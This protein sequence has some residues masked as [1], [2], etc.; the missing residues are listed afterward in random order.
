MASMATAA[1]HAESMA[2]YQ[3]HMHLC[4]LKWSA[5]CIPLNPPLEREMKQKP[6]VNLLCAIRP[7]TADVHRAHMKTINALWAALY[8][9]DWHLHHLWQVHIDSLA[10]GALSAAEHMPLC[11]TPVLESNV[12]VF[13]DFGMLHR[14]QVGLAALSQKPHVE[15][16]LKIRY[17]GDDQVPWSLQQHAKYGPWLSKPKIGRSHFVGLLEVS[18][19]C[20]LWRNGETRSFTVRNQQ[21]Q[22]FYVVA[23]VK[24]VTTAETGQA[25]MQKSYHTRR[26]WEHGVQ[27]LCGYLACNLG[28]DKYGRA[29]VLKDFL[30]YVM[31]NDDY[32]FWDLEH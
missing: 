1:E 28:F 14:L 20:R 13:C 6:A 7:F 2:S 32:E 9:A 31:F 30:D 15:F 29:P 25:H 23:L 27:H 10:V 12:S 17:P 4:D 19:V 21:G 22:Q 18:V 3:R 24:A 5:E 8:R 11:R 16:E 26:A